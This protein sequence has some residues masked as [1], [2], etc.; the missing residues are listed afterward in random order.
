MVQ[1]VGTPRKAEEMESSYV[2]IRAEGGGAEFRRRLERC[3]DVGHIADVS[4]TDGTVISAAMIAVS[5]NALILDR[6]DGPS[7]AAAG[8]PFTLELC[9]SG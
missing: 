5:N 2:W 9:P 6:W 8:D 3:C 4:L 7:G 1:L